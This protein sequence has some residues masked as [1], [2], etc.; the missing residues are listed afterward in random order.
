ME[1][2]LEGENSVFEDLAKAGRKKISHMIPI[3][4][5]YLPCWQSSSPL[6]SK[7][8]NCHAAF[9]SCDSGAVEC[10]FL[11]HV[12]YGDTH[13]DCEGA[14]PRIFLCYTSVAYLDADQTM[15]N[16]IISQFTLGD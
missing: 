7:L 2:V 12:T 9:Q 5:N 8:D 15:Q 10:V 16:S 1:R 14:E 6:A 13:L 3:S 4:S 11:F